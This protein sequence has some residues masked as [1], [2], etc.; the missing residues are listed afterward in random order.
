MS[1]TLGKVAAIFIGVFLMFIVP[2]QL[3]LQREDNL[4][5]MYVITEVTE[6]VDNVRNTGICSYEMYKMFKSSISNLGEMYDIEIENTRKDENNIVSHEAEKDEVIDEIVNTG[7]YYLK[8]NDFIKVTVT[9]KNTIIAY[10]GGS[11]KSENY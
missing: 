7:F 3:M 9:K 1:D 6:F 5:Q 11:I 10:Y 8:E 4:R 2:I